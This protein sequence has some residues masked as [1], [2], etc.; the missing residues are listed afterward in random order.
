[1][2]GIAVAGLVL[3][4]VA[5]YALLFPDPHHRGLVLAASGHAYLP[6]LAHL[7]C[8]LAAASLAAIVARTWVE[9]DTRPAS[10]FAAAAVVLALTQAFAFVGQ[11][12]LE[13]VLSGS[14]LRDLF[15]GP[16]LIVG[17]GAQLLL[18]LGGAALAAWI[19]RTTPRLAAVAVSS[20]IGMWRGAAPLRPIDAFVATPT[21]AFGG[22]H[23][24]RSPPSL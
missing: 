16:L 15:T 21:S 6:S 24:A 2:F 22:V 20:R 7:A 9:R 10:S 18:A 19:R 1:M 23:P 13:R 12:L 4:H 3:G 5:T 14:P 8:I 11:E 17:V